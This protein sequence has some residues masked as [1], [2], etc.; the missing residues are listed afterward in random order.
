MGC[1]FTRMIGR[2][3]E[4]CL[5][6]AISEDDTWKIRDRWQWQ[7]IACLVSFVALLQLEKTVCRSQKSGNN[8][9]VSRSDTTLRNSSRVVYRIVQEI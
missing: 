1:D 4:I 6:R 3:R 5:H 2:T 7:L 8:T 9:N